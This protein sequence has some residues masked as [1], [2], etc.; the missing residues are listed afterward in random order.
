MDERS[1]IDQ[2]FQ[3]H[4]LPTTLRNVIFEDCRFENVDLSGADLGQSKFIDC[5]FQGSS[6]NNAQIVQTHFR[7]VIFVDCSMMGLRFD[8]IR[9]N[10]FSASFTR[11]KLDHSSYVDMNLKSFRWIDCSLKQVLFNGA[12]L[13]DA[14]FSGTDLQSAVFESTILKGADF[15]TAL[16]FHIDPTENKISGARFAS[17]NVQ[18]LLHRWKL[19]WDDE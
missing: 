4:N 18:G 2:V 1:Y 11:C 3:P 14:D 10:L 6:L 16:H 13:T 19:K 8:Y 15:R 9:T 7:D 17:N 5:A 12:D